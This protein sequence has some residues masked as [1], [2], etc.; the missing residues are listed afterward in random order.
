MSDREEEDEGEYV[1]IDEATCSSLPGHLSEAELKDFNEHLLRSNSVYAASAGSEPVG[2]AMEDTS[3]TSLISSDCIIEASKLCPSLPTS[4][5]QELEDPEAVVT[6]GELVQCLHMMMA[7]QSQQIREH[8]QFLQSSLQQLNEKVDSVHDDMSSIKDL[9]GPLLHDKKST[10]SELDALA[11]TLKSEDPTPTTLGKIR[12]II[13]EFE[14]VIH[15][16]KQKCG[17]KM[18]HDTQEWL[19]DTQNKMNLLKALVDKVEKGQKDEMLTRE[20]LSNL[21]GLATGATAGAAILGKYLD[22]PEGKIIGATFGSFIAVLCGQ[23]SAACRK[24][25]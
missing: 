23:V 10:I 19:L 25:F 13:E 9:L 20:N 11:K 21:L 5:S 2:A 16:V 24:Y 22:G 18:D 8:V 6:K 12:G 14:P 1:V 4:C 3:S 7:F 17:Q 15:E